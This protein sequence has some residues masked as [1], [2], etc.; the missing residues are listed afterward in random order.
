MYKDNFNVVLENAQCLASLEM[1]TVRLIFYYSNKYFPSSSGNS[2]QQF[3]VKELC[4]IDNKH[5]LHTP[6][7]SQIATF[8]FHTFDMLLHMHT[9]MHTCIDTHTHTHTHT[10][11]PLRTFETFSIIKYITIDFF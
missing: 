2:Q 3:C 6:S 9:H 10:H 7:H 11:T 5:Y 4:N 8:Q 1:R